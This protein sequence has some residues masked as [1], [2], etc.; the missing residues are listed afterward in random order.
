MMA[1]ENNEKSSQDAPGVAVAEPK[2]RPRPDPRTKGAVNQLPPYNVVL[3]D[4]D[5]HT[6]EYVIEM[7]GVIFTYDV[8][9]S[10]RM[11][12][13]VDEAGRVIVLTTHKEHAELKCDQI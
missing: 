9:K 7:L 5:D 11:G 13:E 8:E 1:D 10:L 4:D 3:L 6:M 2:V 12:T